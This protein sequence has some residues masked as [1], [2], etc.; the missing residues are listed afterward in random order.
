MMAATHTLHPDQFQLFDPADYGHRFQGGKVTTS[1]QER[2]ENDAYMTMQQ[3]Q[4]PNWEQQYGSG[5]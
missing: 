3:Q 4:Q 1:P 2:E 5:V